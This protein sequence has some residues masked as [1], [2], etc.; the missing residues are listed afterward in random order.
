MEIKQ[1]TEEKEIN[2]DYPNYDD[3]KVSTKTFIVMTNITIDTQKLFDYLPITNY[4]IIPKKRGR[5]KKVTPEDPNKDIKNSSIITLR[6]GDQIRGVS[7]KKKKKG[8]KTCFR[9]SLTVVIK[10]DGK[11]INSKISRNGKF[12]ITGAKFSSQAETLVKYI[13][14]YIKDT[15]D[16]FE[17]KDKHFKATFIPAMRN[18][19]FTL[20]FNVDRENLDVEFN[21]GKYENFH[22]LLETTIG[23]TGVN[24]KRLITKSI[25]DLQLK[26]LIYGKK[27]WK[28][29]KHVPYEYYLST[30]S[31]KEQKKKLEKDRYNTF[32]VFQSG[33]VIM[34][35]MCSAFGKDDYYAFIDIIKNNR[36]IFE[37]KLDEI[38]S[39]SDF[40]SDSE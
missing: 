29:T 13:W 5:K 3:I 9:N 28:K 23:Y 40:F 30:M 12:Q 21:S 15:K 1:T 33:K 6:M 19:D 32:L 11:L 34:S 18:I 4:I 8:K 2:H 36:N 31:E 20:G 26:Q 10:I 37:E 27:R 22:S 17:L 25:K 24:V 35:S 39:G 7:L 16:I 14:E 38:S